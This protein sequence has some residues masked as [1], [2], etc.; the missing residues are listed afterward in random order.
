V[1]NM[2]VCGKHV[3]VWYT[4]VCGEHVCVW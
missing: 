2:C 1:V 3:C 4:C